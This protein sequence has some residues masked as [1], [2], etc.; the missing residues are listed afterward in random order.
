VVDQAIEHCELAY[1]ELMRVFGKQ[2]AAA[3]PVI[4]LRSADEYGRFAAG[5][6]GI[7]PVEASGRSSV[8]GAF[9]AEALLAFTSTGQTLPGVAYWDSSDDRGNRFGEMLVRHAAGQSF[10]EAL[11]PS[12]KALAKLAKNEGANGYDD[13]FWGEKQIPQWF[14]Y[15][16]AAYVERY[17]LDAKVAAGGN[18]AWRR[19]WAVQN[20]TSKGGLDP[21]DAI[22]KFQVGTDNANSAKLISEA[23]LLVAF[24]LDGKC[25]EVQEKLGALKDAIKNNKDV[26]K[27]ALALAEEIKKNEAKLRAFAQL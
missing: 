23:G 26:S 7:T 9:L 27:A 4:L 1:R 5:D 18:P 12:P 14:R 10:A 21:I 25:V 8:H 22:F 11:D 20:I 19:E 15:G 24:A 13:L 6:A 17:M 16:A 3:V 2:P